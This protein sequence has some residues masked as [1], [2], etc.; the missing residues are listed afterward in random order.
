MPHAVSGARGR[1]QL[2][3]KTKISS[4]RVLELCEANET[5][6]WAWDRA[7]V[8]Q[9]DLD[10]R[11]SSWPSWRRLAECERQRLASLDR[12]R[13][14]IAEEHA[15]HY[16]TKQTD[17]QQGKQHEVERKLNTDECAIL[18]SRKG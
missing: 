16:V 2:S 7:K 5:I 15:H 17:V 4:D 11:R 12:K 1:E 14:L 3:E 13:E 8:D 18:H 6:R 9:K 10:E